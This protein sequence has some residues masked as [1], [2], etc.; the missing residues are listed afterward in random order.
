M[1]LKYKVKNI[2]FV[3]DNVDILPNIIEKNNEITQK[4]ME[5]CLNELKY[6]SLPAIIKEAINKVIHNKILMIKES[7]DTKIEMF[8]KNIKDIF[9]QNV[10]YSI[11]SYLYTTQKS[12]CILFGYYII[13]IFNGD[14]DNVKRYVEITMW[15]NGNNYTITKTRPLYDF[16][17]CELGRDVYWN[18]FSKI[19]NLDFSCFGNDFVKTIENTKKLISERNWF[20]VRCKNQK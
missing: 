12:I 17:K 11:S 9:G 7:P 8:N 4:D 13:N 1:T 20:V 15:G 3:F 18:I 16:Q 10:H 19:L 14:V 2:N 5:D 6:I